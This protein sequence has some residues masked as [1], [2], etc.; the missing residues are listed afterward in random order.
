V[1]RVPAC[2]PAR[3]ADGAWQQRTIA[4]VIDVAIARDSWR[5]GV[6]ASCVAPG[7]AS[8]HGAD[9]LSLRWNSSCSGRGTHRRL[10]QMDSVRVKYRVDDTSHLDEEECCER[11]RMQ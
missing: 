7:T 8:R 11:K 3:G 1:Q 9:A 6:R 5:E 10:D 2:C 4:L